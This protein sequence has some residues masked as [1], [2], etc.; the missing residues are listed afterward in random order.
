MTHFVVLIILSR[1]HVNNYHTWNFVCVVAARVRVPGGS[2]FS[3]LILH[4]TDKSKVVR[5]DKTYVFDGQFERNRS[6][7]TNSKTN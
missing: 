2:P 7:Q 3:Q 4:E 6:K 1:G 5:N